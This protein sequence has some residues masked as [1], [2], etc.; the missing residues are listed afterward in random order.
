MARM[1]V[2]GDAMQRLRM[3]RAMSQADLAD[4]AGVRQATV[5]NAENGRNVRYATILAIAG[6]LGV[7]V[8]SLIEVTE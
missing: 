4:V 5:S 7:E 6:A 2:K 8:A 3:E 1:K